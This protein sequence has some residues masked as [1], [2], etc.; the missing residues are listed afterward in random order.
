MI[1]DMFNYFFYNFYSDETFVCTYLLS[2]A[3]RSK[4]SGIKVYLKDV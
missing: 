1:I 4:N 3:N 2:T